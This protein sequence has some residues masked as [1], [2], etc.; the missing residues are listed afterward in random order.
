[1][2]LVIWHWHRVNNNTHVLNRVKLIRDQMMLQISANQAAVCITICNLLE[3]I[4][5]LCYLCFD[6]LISR[7][8]IDLQLSSLLHRVASVQGKTKNW[9]I[10][11]VLNMWFAQQ[12][13]FIEPYWG[14]IFC[15]KSEWGIN[16]VWK[17][18]KSI[19]N[20][21][22]L[23]YLLYGLSMCFL[24]SRQIYI[25]LCFALVIFS[26]TLVRMSHR[27]C[28]QSSEMSLGAACA[29]KNQLHNTSH[30]N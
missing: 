25:Y 1:M 23:L 7:P 17:F 16:Y 3:R 14:D 29:T 27:L 6:S 10:Y 19:T 18:E 8:K 2:Q 30:L 21:I 12:V 26:W 20:R 28:A 15:P 24:Q 13:N 4:S 22:D 5:M 9:W 11:T